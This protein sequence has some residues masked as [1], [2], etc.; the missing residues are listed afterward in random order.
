MSWTR[1]ARHEA[2]RLGVVGDDLAVAERGDDVLGPV[3]RADQHAVAGRDREP[4]RLGL[5]EQLA[6]GR[7][8]RAHGDGDLG[9]DAERGDVGERALAHARGD[10]LLGHRRGRGGVVVAERL[11]EA[12]ER[13]AQLELAEDLAQLRAVGRPRGLGDRVDLDAGRRA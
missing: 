1:F 13:R 10:R 6:L 3:A 4:P 5:G 2:Q 12:L 11:L 8:R 9:V 7:R